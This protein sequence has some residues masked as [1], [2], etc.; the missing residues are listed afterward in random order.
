M[1]FEASRRIRP[2]PSVGRDAGHEPA[3][4]E[5]NMNKKS[6]L[7]GF[8]LV[9]ALSGMAFAHGGGGKKMDQ[10]QDGKVTLDEALAGAK[11]RF[12]K[13]DANKDGAITKDEAKGRFQRRLEKKD[14]NGDGKLT[15]V[16]MET[17]V[18]SWFQSADKNKDAVLSGDELGQ[19]GGGHCQKGEKDKT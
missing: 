18:R 16:E 2:T 17:G 15:L 1:F 10:N 6:L 19:R 3:H 7:I 4:E 13:V 9:T 5:S 11:A 8:S 14:S 12:A